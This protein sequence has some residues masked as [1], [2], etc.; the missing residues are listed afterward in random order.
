MVNYNAVIVHYA[1]IGLKGSNRPYFE[2]LLV[3]N[4]MIALRKTNY[5]EIK[6][7]YGSVIIYLKNNADIK[8]IKDCL[9]NIPGI[10]SYSLSVKGNASLKHIKKHALA[11]AAENKKKSFRIDT[12][13]SDKSF[14]MSSIQL[15]E[16]IGSYVVEKTGMKVKLKN[17]GLTIYIELIGGEAFLYQEKTQ[18][19]G[20]LPVDSA[21]KLVSLLSGG[22]DSP[23][24]SFLM[25][26]RGAHIIFI[27][28]RNETQSTSKDKIKSLVKILTKYQL[29]SKLYIVDFK[30]IQKEIIMKIPAKQRM[31][32]YR[33]VMLRI[34]E[35]ILEK[36]KAEGFVT[37][38]SVAQV[39]S[40]TLDNLKVIYDAAGYPVFAPLI[41]L[42]KQ[43]IVD[44]AHKIGTYETSILPYSDCCSFLIAKHPDTKADLEIIEKME[45]NLDFEKIMKLAKKNI[46]RLIL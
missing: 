7:N 28:F 13:R 17:P 25:M 12:K 8:K 38:D 31:I 27:H 5:E 2:K 33:R 14:K 6:R 43:E 22:I 40:Q 3:R 41:G 46:E 34:A 23:V 4:I 45:E 11:I 20:G 21:G 18:G 16:K 10:S 37:G 30:N 26:K 19:L 42:N 24:A 32:I 44:I 15:N 9:K 36:E 29:S 35:S 39:A 1:E